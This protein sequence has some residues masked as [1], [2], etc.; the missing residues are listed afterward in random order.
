[1]MRHSAKNKY[2]TPSE[3]MRA[4]AKYT[5]RYRFLHRFYSCDECPYWHLAT[6][7]HNGV[8]VLSLDA[9]QKGK[10]EG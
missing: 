2:T 10:G 1:M 3:A 6:V 9:I 4:A 7:R 8:P 5:R